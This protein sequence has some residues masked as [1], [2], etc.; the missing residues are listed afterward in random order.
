[1]DLGQA[2]HDVSGEGELDGGGLT[3]QSKRRGNFERGELCDRRRLGNG[4]KVSEVKGLKLCDGTRSGNQPV[5]WIGNV[6]P[7]HPKD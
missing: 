6:I 2:A 5:D 7:I 3:R 4:Q 1:M